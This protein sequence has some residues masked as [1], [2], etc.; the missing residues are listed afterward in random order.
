MST[1]LARI[2]DNAERIVIARY[3]MCPD[4]NINKQS[5][6]FYPAKNNGKRINPYCKL[7][8]NRRNKVGQKNRSLA[9]SKAK[10]SAALSTAAGSLLLFEQ[11]LTPLG[12]KH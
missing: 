10:P 9:H 6:E 5:S 1:Q 8:H 4:C 11:C 2:A 7:C 12:K 3:I